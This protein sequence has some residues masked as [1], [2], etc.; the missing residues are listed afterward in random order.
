MTA[1]DALFNND[2]IAGGHLGSHFQPK[3]QKGAE[4]LGRARFNSLSSAI[5]DIAKIES[6]GNTSAVRSPGSVEH[7]RPVKVRNH[8]PFNM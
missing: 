7:L 3:R 1:D 4:T 5:M 8:S 6:I 2:S